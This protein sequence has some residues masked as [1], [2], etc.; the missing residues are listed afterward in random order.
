[1]AAIG[2]A[3]WFPQE[4][5]SPPFV[6]V[7]RPDMRAMAWIRDNTAP[8][9]RF[10]VEGFR[11]YAGFTAVGADAGWW[12]PLL[13]GRPN[14][15]PPQYALLSEQPSPPDYTQRVVDLVAQLEREP[16]GAPQSLRLLCD[17]GI[18]YVY[19]G[20]GQ[21]RVGV[22]APQLFAPQQ[23]IDSPAFSLVYR[24][25]RVAIFQLRPELCETSQ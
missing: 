21:G 15:M 11:V 20:Q 1:L 6:M 23:L 10:L 4:E 14:T 9:A 7:T 13:A 3:L 12:I 18:G 16:P 22:S 25:D 2:W 24:Q 19:I 17:W 5:P 8:D